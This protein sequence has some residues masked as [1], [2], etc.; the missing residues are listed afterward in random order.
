MRPQV[1]IKALNYQAMVVKRVSNHANTMN[2][3]QKKRLTG[4]N[5][6]LCKRSLILVGGGSFLALGI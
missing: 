6:S 4:L 5:L 3:K 1:V 2:N